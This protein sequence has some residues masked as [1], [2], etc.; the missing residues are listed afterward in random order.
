MAYCV[1]IESI[2]E[3]FFPYYPYVHFYKPPT[4]T[5][6]EI[7]QKIIYTYLEENLTSIFL[8]SAVVFSFARPRAV[9]KQVNVWGVWGSIL[10]SQ[11]C[12]ILNTFL[13]NFF[14]KVALEVNASNASSY[15]NIVQ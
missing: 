4:F 8:V 13:S 2:R 7:L 12:L 10:K 6:L 15:G 1:V 3:K 9:E 11:K 5:R 14:S